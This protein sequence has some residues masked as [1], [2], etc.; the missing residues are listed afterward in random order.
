[1]LY[2]FMKP[3]VAILGMLPNMLRRYQHSLW[4]QLITY[5][6]LMLNELPQMRE[7]AIL[8]STLQTVPSMKML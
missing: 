1:M 6:S 8:C 2:D 3:L 7:L 4:V 5:T